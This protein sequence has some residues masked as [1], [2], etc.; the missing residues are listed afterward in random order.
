MFRHICNLVMNA[1]TITSSSKNQRRQE[2]DRRDLERL[3]IIEREVSLLQFDQRVI[4]EE[5]QRENLQVAVGGSSSGRKSARPFQKLV[6]MQQEKNKRDKHIRDRVSKEKKHE[7]HRTEKRDDHVHKGVQRTPGAVSQRQQHRSK[8]SM[9]SAFFQFM[10]PISSAFTS[11]HPDPSGAK[12]TPAELDFAPS[13]KPILVLNVVDAKVAQF[14]NNE[15]SFTFQ[16]DT[17]DGGHYLLQAI[18]RREMTKWL[19]TI[20]R[21]SKTAAKRRLTYIG[22][23]KPQLADHIHNPTTSSRDPRA[24]KLPMFV[25]V[26]T[27]KCS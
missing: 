11:E 27:S 15:R 23:P 26:R 12:R 4:R 8:K 9:S 21:V 16:L 3:N 2:I 7:Q 5:A 20:N 22:S 14:I 24:G 19:D 17:E 10:R 6:V 25:V 1:P 18:S 13:G